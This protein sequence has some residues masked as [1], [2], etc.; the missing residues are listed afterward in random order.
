MNMIKK[1]ML[2]LFIFA[3]SVISFSQ[4]VIKNDDG[5][6]TMVSDTMIYLDSSGHNIDMKVFNDSLATSQYNVSFKMLT[7]GIENKLI[8]KDIT[9]S[10]DKL[11]LGNEF[12]NLELIDIYQNKIN[13][14]NTLITLMSFWSVEC[15]PCIE[16]L[17][18]F[19]ILANEYPEV[20]FI[21]IT[22][23]SKER[24]S[25]FLANS[26]YKWDNLIIVPES[27]EYFDMLD[28]L[29]TPLNI[30]VDNN[31]IIKMASTG[32]NIRGTLRSIEELIK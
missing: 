25:E 3:C 27:Q 31:R 22:Y 9:K 10:N 13:L 16:E 5:S 15:R 19:N 30:I 12:P 7:N 26:R 1:T 21:A 20:S 14:D 28:I 6:I 11:Q 8:K 24:V 17:T 18:V 32:K 2:F 29:A 4:E 23:N